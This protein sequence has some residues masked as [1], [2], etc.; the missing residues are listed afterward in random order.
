MKIQFED[1]S[2]IE[3]KKSDT[4]GKI[5]VMISAKDHQNPLVKITNTVELTPEEFKRL[6]SDVNS[7]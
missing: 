7:N 3:C 6:I 1:K 4:P 2:Y 5:T